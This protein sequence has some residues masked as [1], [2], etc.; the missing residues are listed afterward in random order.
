MGKNLQK[1]VE[2]KTYSILF[3]LENELGIE[4]GKI[5][6]VYYIGKNFSFKKL[7]ISK[8][9]YQE[10]KNIKKGKEAFFIPSES[11]ILTRSLKKM[12]LAEEVGHFI[13]YNFLNSNKNSADIFASYTISE[14]IGF[15][16]SKLI[17]SNRK[18]GFWGDNLMYKKSLQ[19]ILNGIK[20]VIKKGEYIALIHQ[21]GYLLGNKL[22]NGY[23]SNQISK[24][25]IKKLIKN[26][27]SKKY[28]AFEKFINLKY[29]LL[30]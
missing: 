26:P 19:G 3:D 13:H 9:Y 11:M 30:L 1:V 24:K 29:N 21:Q 5:P 20:Y 7:G 27:L 2:E 28:E 4:T 23:L 17:N 12:V 6:E 10:F 16:C 22:Y 25:Q 8:E 14:M 18:S 15:F